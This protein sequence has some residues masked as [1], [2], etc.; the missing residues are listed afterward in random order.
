MQINSRTR[1]SQHLRPFGFLGTKP[2]HRHLS[3][4]ELRSLEVRALKVAPNATNFQRAGQNQ[5]KSISHQKE[6]GKQTKHTQQCPP[7][8]SRPSPPPLSLS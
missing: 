4:T 5:S 7:S 3:S 6:G 1:V 2:P 8:T